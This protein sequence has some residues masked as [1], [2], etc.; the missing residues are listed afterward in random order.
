MAILAQL[1]HDVKPIRFYPAAKLNNG[2][3][4]LDLF[5][6]REQTAY[7]QQTLCYRKNE[8]KLIEDWLS[9][10][11]M[12]HLFRHN[13]HQTKTDVFIPGGGRPRTLNEQ[14]YKDFLDET[15]KPTSRAIIEGANLYL[16]PKAR[17]ALETLGV[18]IIKDSSANKGGV[19]CS[20]FEVLCGLILSE[21]EFIA[22]KPKLMPEI[23]EAIRE[24]A[25]DEAQL[26]LR[27]YS[28]TG[29]YLTDLSEKTSEKINYLKYELL[30]YLAPM[31]LEKN[32]QDLFIRCLLKYCPPLLRTNYQDRILT[33]IPDIHKKAIIATY[34]ASK[35]VYKRGLNW[36][37]SLIDVIPM[38]V[39]E[40]E[41]INP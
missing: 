18:I 31:T 8:G 17:R 14:N 27:T 20:S 25:R 16:T 5:T 41:I 34:I 21:E 6:K 2:G 9:G 3:F 32:P 4:L 37:P 29:A 22:L 19:I 38:I 10:N 1:F 26:L 23:L 36:A 15:G 11:E 7:A 13:M 12:N 33:E 40:I 35:I 39:K 28:Q 30:G 24:R